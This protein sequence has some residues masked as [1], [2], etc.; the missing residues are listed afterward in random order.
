MQRETSKGRIRVDAAQ[1]VKCGALAEEPHS[2]RGSERRLECC[3]SVRE[4]LG[5]NFEAFDAS[6]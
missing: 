6:K 3:V 4:H 2:S 1:A 5:C